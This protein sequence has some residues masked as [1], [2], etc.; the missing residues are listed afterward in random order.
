MVLCNVYA[1][2]LNVV[3]LG[4]LIEEI[5]QLKYVYPSLSLNPLVRCH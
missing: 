5:V 3:K 1:L 2:L 4:L